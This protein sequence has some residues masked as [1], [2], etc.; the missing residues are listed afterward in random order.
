MRGELGLNTH[1][2]KVADHFNLYVV[3]VTRS[4]GS[5]E[6]KK[7]NGNGNGGSGNQSKKTGQARKGKNETTKSRGRKELGG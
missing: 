7:S 5:M 2:D 4:W 6:P 1:Y 3:L